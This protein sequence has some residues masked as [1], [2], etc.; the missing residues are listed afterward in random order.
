[1]LLSL[2]CVW[3][4]SSSFEGSVQ[5]QLLLFLQQGKM[6]VP[7]NLLYWFHQKMKVFPPLQYVCACVSLLCSKSNFITFV[8]N[9]LNELIHVS[10]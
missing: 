7:S 1:M 8:R 5:V 10:I 3:R 2:R 9:L 6:I 4:H